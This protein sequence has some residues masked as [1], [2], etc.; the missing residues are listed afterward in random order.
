MRGFI[1]EVS[2]RLGLDKGLVE[3]DF[4]L[5][6]I[7]LDLS[8]SHFA[9][10]FAFKGGSCLIKHYIGYYRFS[11]D[12]DF[13]FLNQ[14]IFEGLSQKK[15]RRLL[16]GQIDTI[17]E[18]FEEISKKRNLNF[19]CEKGER[20]YVELGGGNKFTTF[21]LW[22]PSMIGVES[23]I[24]IQ[25]NFVEK[26]LFPIKDVKLRSICPESKE[27]ELLYP[28]YYSEYRKPI[29]F[30]VYDIREIL[31]EK[32]RAILTRRGFKERD[33]IDIYL[34]SKRIGMDFEEL[35][36]ETLEK[37]K[38]ILELYQKYRRNLMEKASILT[39]ENF[40]FGSERQLLITDINKADFYSFL[41]RFMPWLRKLTRTVLGTYNP[42]NP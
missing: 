42:E 13:T 3:R 15:I 24:K 22:F 11:V 5:H 38:F 7:L 28:T 39:I 21:K 2:S 33:F 26:I 16:S 30:K 6:Q 35:E 18:L 25:I 20:R 8:D 1:E 34:I 12:L 9:D 4:L 41:T 27:L 14:Q 37:L 17:G 32:V 36:R 31:C 23:L 19:K 10:D 29:S 40:P